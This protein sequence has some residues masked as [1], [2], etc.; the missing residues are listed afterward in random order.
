MDFGESP[1][2]RQRTSIDV[3]DRV[4]DDQEY[5]YGG[6][7]YV[8]QRGPHSA[9][10]SKPPTTNYG[11]GYFYG[12]Q[13]APSS[14]SEYS[15][16]HQRTQSSS[17]SSPYVSPRT[18]IPGYSSSAPNPFYQ[19]Q[20]REPLYSYQQ[21]QQPD[22]Q[23][24]QVPQLAQPV[25]PLRQ[26]QLLSQPQSGDSTTYS[27]ALEMDDR[28]A[29]QYRVNPVPLPNQ[30]VYYPT[31]SLLP[32][33]E[34]PIPLGQSRLQPLQAPMPN[35]LPPLES[36]V[37]PGHARGAVTQG[38]SEYAVPTIEAHAFMPIASQLNSERG[39][40]SYATQSVDCTSAAHLKRDNG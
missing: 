34:R 36:T 5:K 1:S 9:Y 40:E 35:V 29:I 15:F 7:S 12:P 17:T 23:H 11:S 38:R 19:Q 10:S 32:F 30:P 22:Y 37:T 14:V 13:S 24:R 39:Q 2:K 28:S 21:S 18:E 8:E 25:A 3:G 33:P 31:T 26:H 4:I 20:T 6:R 27:R 16:K